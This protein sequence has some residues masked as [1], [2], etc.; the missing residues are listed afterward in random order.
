MIENLR[1]CIA[2]KVILDEGVDQGLPKVFLEGAALV[3]AP[4]G[5]GMFSR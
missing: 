3:A 1:R 4:G 5:F 2:G